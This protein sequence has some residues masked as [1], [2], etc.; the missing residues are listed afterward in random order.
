MA[1]GLPLPSM[2]RPV[3]PEYAV[4]AAYG[5]VDGQRMLAKFS[6][7]RFPMS[8]DVIPCP[9]VGVGEL[10]WCRANDGAVLFVQT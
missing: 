10:I 4:R 5:L 9:P 8:T 2:I 3:C 6:L 7:R 1:Q